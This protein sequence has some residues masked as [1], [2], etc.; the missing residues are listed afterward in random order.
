MTREIRFS[1]DILQVDERNGTITVPMAKEEL[2]LVEEPK[3]RE[4]AT[5]TYE[6][7]RRGSRINQLESGRRNTRTASIVSTTIEQPALSRKRSIKLQRMMSLVKWKRS[8]SGESSTASFRQEFSTRILKPN[9]YFFFS[10]F[11]SLFCFLP[12]GKYF[13]ILL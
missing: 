10:V 9:D 2:D 3:T 12:I 8:Q 1:E 7:G 13:S 6:T 5:E 4:I 11:T